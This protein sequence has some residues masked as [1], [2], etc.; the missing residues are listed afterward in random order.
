[1][2]RISFAFVVLLMVAAFAASAQTTTGTLVTCES[3]NNVRHTCTVDVRQGVSLSRQLSNNACVRGKTWG[4][5]RN[6]KGIWVDDG[7]RAEFLVGGNPANAGLTGYPRTI[8]CN[9]GK[10][11]GNRCPAD[12]SMGVQLTRQVSKHSCVL[13]TDW[14]Y[15]QTG[16]W[17]KNGCRGEF[18]IG[19][20]YAPMASSLS[21]SVI[22]ESSDG[23]TQRC[24]ANTS[25]GVALSR[26]L[27]NSSCV[28]GQ[29]WGYDTEG[30]W[31]SNGCRAEFLLGRNP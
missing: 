7:C 31:V 15:D 17:V 16:I 25:F 1:M 21:N 30:V 18:T 13:G 29:T 20:G 22:C 4:T 19:S 26:Q 5:T 10:K 6:N 2:R 9:A 12:T 3:I 24:S 8:V 28:K 11:H 14:G 23:R 27:S